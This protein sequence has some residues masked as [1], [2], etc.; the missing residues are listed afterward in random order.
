MLLPAIC[1]YFSQPLSSPFI[2]IDDL[3]NNLS[4][5]Q[6]AINLPSVLT[7][8]ILPSTPQAQNL[9]AAVLNSGNDKEIIIHMP[10]ESVYSQVNKSNAIS[11]KKTISAPK[12][13]KL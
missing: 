5:G 3:A 6:Q 1:Q 11:A 4:L 9:A 8:G 10:M 12:K 13:L 7:Y 2:I